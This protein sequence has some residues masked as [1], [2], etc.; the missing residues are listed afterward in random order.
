MH[1]H[2][3]AYRGS[4]FGG[5]RCAGEPLKIIAIQQRTGGWRAE[6]SGLKD[7]GLCLLWRSDEIHTGMAAAIADGRAQVTR[8]QAQGSGE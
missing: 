6:I 3:L 8:L 5:D 1:R 4:G 2:D 7:G